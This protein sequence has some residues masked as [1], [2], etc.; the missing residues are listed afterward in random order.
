MSMRLSIPLETMSYLRTFDAEIGILTDNEILIR[1][2]M[3][4]HRFGFEHLWRVRTPEYEV[5]DA[6]AT[7]IAGEKRD[8]DPALCERYAGINGVRVGRGFSKR[9]ISA[10]GELP[11]AKEHLLLS[12]EMAR[13]AQQVYQFP[14]EF[15]ARFQGQP[16]SAQ[17]SWSKDRAF[18]GDLANSCYTY[19]D[20]TAELFASREVRVGFPEDLYRPKPGDKRAFWRNKRVSIELTPAGYVVE[21][22]MDD[23][24]HDIQIGF[25]L[26]REGMISNPRS[27]G[28][29]LP[30]H[31]IC[32]D[33]Q[34]RTSGLA[35]M[36]VTSSFI[37]QFADRIGGSQGCTHLF[38]LSI[39]ALRLF[40]FVAD[41]A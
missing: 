26:T 7:Q 25:D 24:I 19:R 38:D 13:I 2:V 15:E 12:I 40:D 20:A 18:M 23:L 31:G 32:E 29:R 3:S 8:F 33:A 34:L 37:L 14:P 16:F 28:L 5:L 22:A 30:Y 21:S 4:D 27:R 9:V 36:K 1:G 10:L 35:G 6:R 17:L 11:G 39:D 41:P